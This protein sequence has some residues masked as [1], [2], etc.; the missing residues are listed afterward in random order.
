[1]GLNLLSKT[2]S[3]YAL[4]L[5]FTN[6]NS[7]GVLR[8]PVKIV[9]LRNFEL[10]MSGAIQFCEYSEEMSRYF[11]DEKEIVMYRSK[12][13]FIDKARFYLDPNKASMRENIRKAARL[14][15]EKDHTWH[16]RFQKIF[17]ELGIA[18]K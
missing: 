3:Q 17:N 12:E 18:F 7:T 10:P 14:R 16:N 15:A 13:D 8:N 5:S 1:V 2:N 9:N 11:E 6:A 4:T